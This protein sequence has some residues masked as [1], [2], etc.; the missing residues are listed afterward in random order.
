[1]VIGDNSIIVNLTNEINTKINPINMKFI[2]IKYK[3]ENNDLILE[4][5]ISE[6]DLL[7][8]GLLREWSNN[9]STT[10][11][12]LIQNIENLK[13]K[14]KNENEEE[15]YTYEYSKDDIEKINKC[16]IEDIV[17][18]KYYL[19]YID[20]TKYKVLDVEKIYTPPTF[21]ANGKVELN[22]ATYTW[23]GKGN[24]FVTVDTIS[25]E[26][27]LKDKEAFNVID[28][29]YI[30]LNKSNSNNLYKLPKEATLKYMV[31]N[32]DETFKDA[33]LQNDGSYLIDLPKESGEYICE[34]WL[35]C[36]NNNN[37]YSYYCLKIKV[38]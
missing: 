4:C 27:M 7:N 12:V 20:Y 22:Q 23:K 28:K 25:P 14:I 33:A 2:D 5:Y 6:N 29:L 17:L 18:S 21:Y 24:S 15:K 34:F 3:I 1:M 8:E 26:E 13:I 9:Y 37:M 31:S 38:M 10:M 19:E 30:S 35:S 11:F 32:L 16:N 36:N